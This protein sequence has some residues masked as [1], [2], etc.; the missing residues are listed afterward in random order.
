MRASLKL[1]L[2]GPL[3]CRGNRD[4][5]SP[6]RREVGG[7]S[8]IGVNFGNTA[9]SLKLL[10]EGPLIC[11]GNRDIFSPGRSAVG[12]G[13][14]GPPGNGLLNT[15][16]WWA[17]RPLQWNGLRHTRTSGLGVLRRVSIPKWRSNKVRAEI[18]S[19]WNFWTTRTSLGSLSERGLD[20]GHCGDTVAEFE[21]ELVEGKEASVF[22][23]HLCGVEESDEGQFAEDAGGGSVVVAQFTFEALSDFVRNSNISQQ[24]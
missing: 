22:V 10:L 12:D 6:G 20:D 7:R 13:D 11:R 18:L 21:G 23:E 2:E 5:F 15:M 19:K 24:F 8:R 9:A 4:I 1:L 3:I 16:T 14:G 17:H